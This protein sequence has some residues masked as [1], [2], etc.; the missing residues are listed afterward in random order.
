MLPGT[1]SSGWFAELT[2]KKLKRGTH[3][4]VRELNM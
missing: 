4:S 2:T 1:P 3:R